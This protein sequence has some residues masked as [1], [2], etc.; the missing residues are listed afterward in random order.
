M[1]HPGAN[2]VG[3]RGVDV[4]LHFL[5]ELALEGIATKEAREPGH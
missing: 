4:E 1:R 3:D 2:V 5:L